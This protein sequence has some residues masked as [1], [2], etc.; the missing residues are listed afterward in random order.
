M[1]DCPHPTLP[2]THCCCGWKVGW[3]VGMTRDGF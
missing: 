2:T 3:K 1:A